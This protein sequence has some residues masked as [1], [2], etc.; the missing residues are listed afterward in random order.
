[1]RNTVL[2]HLYCNAQ[3][4]SSISFKEAK[5]LKEKQ[6]QQQQTNNKQQQQQQQQNHTQLSTAEKRRLLKQAKKVHINI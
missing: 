4:S 3:N 6:Q 5:D 2:L 1:V